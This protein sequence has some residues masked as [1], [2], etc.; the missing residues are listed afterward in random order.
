LVVA[1]AVGNYLFGPKMPTQFTASAHW[2]TA[3][4]GRKKELRRIQ[5]NFALAIRQPVL[6]GKLCFY[7]NM[8]GPWIAAV[9]VA[10]SD[11]SSMK[12]SGPR[13]SVWHIETITRG[14]PKIIWVPNA[15]DTSART[16][17]RIHN[18]RWTAILPRPGTPPFSRV[19]PS[20]KLVP[21]PP[22]KGMW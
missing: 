9:A 22:T 10:N 14:Q 16:W 13:Q 21:W 17:N 18:E 15:L 19:L 8:S 6:D 20:K 5:E 3:A 2:F 4:H 12:R 11:Q 1:I 7:R